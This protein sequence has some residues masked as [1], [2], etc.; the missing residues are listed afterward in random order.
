[1][2]VHTEAWKEHGWP[3]RMASAEIGVHPQHPQLRPIG[4]CQSQT[5]VSSRSKIINISDSQDTGSR[6][7]PTRIDTG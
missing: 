2:G 3:R 5:P 1:M 7:S 4:V 6:E